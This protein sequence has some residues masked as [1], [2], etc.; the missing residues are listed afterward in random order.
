MKRE[1]ASRCGGPVR[2]V[3]L[4]SGIFGLRVKISDPHLAAMIAIG[5]RASWVMRFCRGHRDSERLRD[6]AKASTKAKLNRQ[7][8]VRIDVRHNWSGE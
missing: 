4:F 1:I 5:A 3:D 8:N 6:D 2:A 7:E